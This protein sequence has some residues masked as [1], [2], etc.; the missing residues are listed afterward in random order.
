MA[1]AGGGAVFVTGGGAVFIGGGGA[2][3]GGGVGAVF[4]GGAGAVFVTGGGGVPSRASR[5]ATLRRAMAAFLPEG[6]VRKNAL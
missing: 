6:L 2:M 3:Y 4:G 5:E 1:G